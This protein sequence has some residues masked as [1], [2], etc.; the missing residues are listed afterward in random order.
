MVSAG[1]AVAAAPVVAAGVVSA[2]TAVA[3]A[4]VVVA[5][6]FKGASG[7]SGVMPGPSS[8]AGTSTMLF[9][10]QSSRRRSRGSVG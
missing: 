10:R 1:T 7:A 4:P 6:V 2:G 5:G 9:A 8:D 3:A